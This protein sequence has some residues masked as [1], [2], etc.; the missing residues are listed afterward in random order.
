MDGVNQLHSRA[1]LEHADFAHQR[2][3]HVLS[4][5]SSRARKIAKAEG[6]VHRAAPEIGAVSAKAVELFL[7]YLTTRSADQMCRENRRVLQYKDVA[8]AVAQP[9]SLVFLRDVVP[10]KVSVSSLIAN[11]AG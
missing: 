10:P 1:G 6:D 7:G 5:P 4:A 8:A 11:S 2:D 9:G 3:T